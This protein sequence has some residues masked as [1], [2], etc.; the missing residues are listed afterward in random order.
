MTEYVGRRVA[1]LAD[2]LTFKR[3]VDKIQE[4]DAAYAVFYGSDFKVT[5]VQWRGGGE[6]VWIPHTLG[7]E[8]LLRGQHWDEVKVY[9]KLSPLEQEGVYNAIAS[10]QARS[11]TN[12]GQVAE[13]RSVGE[14]PV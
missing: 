2:A 4:E 12:E 5:R 3:L 6:T 11:R 14:R 7:W 9:V 10:K 1:V 8:Q 13:E